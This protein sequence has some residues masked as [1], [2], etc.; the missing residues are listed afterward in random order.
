GSTLSFAEFATAMFLI[1]RRLAG[2][3][4]PPAIPDAT[5]A[6]ILAANAAVASAASANAAAAI[7]PSAAPPTAVPMYRSPSVPALAAQPPA[8]ALGA[9]AVPAAPSLERSLTAGAAQVQTGSWAITPQEKAHY[10]SLFKKGGRD[11]PT[12]LPKELVPAS[13]RDLDSMAESMK[14]LVMN[15]IVQSKQRQLQGGNRLGSQSSLADDPL[16]GGFGTGR[17]LSYSGQ[18]KEIQ[19]AERQR[20]A[21]QLEAKRKEVA[22]VSHRLDAS[23]TAVKDVDREAD[24]NR[25]AAYDAFDDVS[26]RVRAIEGL[27]ERVKD[28]KTSKS[29]TSTVSFDRVAV[30]AEASA[31][32]ADADALESE[33]LALADDCRSLIRAAADAKSTRARSTSATNT[34]SSTAGGDDVAARAEALLAERMAALGLSLSS[35]SST[36]NSGLSSELDRIESERRNREADID[37]VLTK[38]RHLAAEARSAAQNASTGNGGGAADSPASE[39]ASRALAALKGWEPSIDDKL[40]FE[41]GVGLRSQPV[42]DAVD[43][44]KRKLS[45]RS[46]PL[47]AYSASSSYGPSATTAAPSPGPALETRAVDNRAA[48]TVEA[49]PA[50]SSSISSEVASASARFPDLADWSIGGTATSVRIF[51]CVGVDFLAVDRR[52]VRAWRRTD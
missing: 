23:R 45:L 15:D 37:L 13:T 12:V 10:E 50:V 8:T 3:D 22:S 18:S 2:Q 33:I 31:V 49:K 20:L 27:V 40:R 38:A 30:T 46:N 51:C 34:T 11:L 36:A 9:L 43:S 29:S 5:K 14:S 39:I 21:D 48:R 52:S 26:Y 44:F 35:S 6:Q 25:R 32:I 19:E 47:S 24:R 7:V 28:V 17:S 4:V 16:F 1:R 42:R 41:E